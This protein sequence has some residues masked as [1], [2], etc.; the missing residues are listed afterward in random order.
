MSF[1]CLKNLAPLHELTEPKN[2][3]RGR[4]GFLLQNFLG[5][6]KMAMLMLLIVFSLARF[7]IK[8][9]ELPLQIAAKLG[10]Y[11]SKKIIFSL[12]CKT[13]KKESSAKN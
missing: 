10:Q 6:R 1:I 4:L 5:G 9:G 7:F 2:S 8:E 13:D 11:P 3:A 12:K